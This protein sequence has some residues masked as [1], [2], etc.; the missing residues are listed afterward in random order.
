[1]Q[2]WKVF[3]CRNFPWEKLGDGRVVRQVRFIINIKISPN[4]NLH[5]GQNLPVLERG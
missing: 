1:M 4:P 2:R 3:P 5:Q